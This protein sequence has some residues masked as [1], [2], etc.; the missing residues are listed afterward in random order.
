LNSNKKIVFLKADK[1]LSYG[2]VIEVMDIIKLAGVDT[3]GMIVEQ[4]SRQ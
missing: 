4:K 2:Y 1:S 3:V